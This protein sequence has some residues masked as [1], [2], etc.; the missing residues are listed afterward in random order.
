MTRFLTSLF[1]LAAIA[2]TVALSASCGKIRHRGDDGY[3]KVMIFYTAGYNSLSSYIREDLEDLKKGYLPAAKSR[4]A[5]ILISKL[6]V[7]YG[8]YN[9]KT[10][11]CIIRITGKKSGK[12]TVAVMDTLMTLEPGTVLANSRVTRECLEYVRDRFPSKSYGMVFSSHATGWL[13]GGYFDNPSAY[14]RAFSWRSGQNA[15]ASAGPLYVEREQDPSYPAVKS[16]TQE[17]ETIDKWKYSRE[18]EIEDLADAI[19]M[20]LD[21]LLFDACLMG[22]IEVAYAFRN[23][24]DVIGFS[25]TEVLADGYDYT[26]ITGHL[27]GRSEPDAKSV[28]SDFFNSYEIQTGMNRSATVSLVEC[29]KVGDIAQVC[30]RLFSKYRDSINSLSQFRV[31]GYFYNQ[32]RH[33]HFDLLDIIIQAGATDEEISE[34]RRVLDASLIYKAATPS[35]FELPLETTCGYSMYLPSAGSAYLDNFYRSLSWNQATHLVSE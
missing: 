31:Q 1:R 4:D 2:M 7:S 34:L 22:G 16:V 10:S 24:A 32:A 11:P 17:V 19:P 12:T 3:D 21:Y 20:H 29:S 15:R 5:L 33:W 6:P 9:T 28:C 23:V 25:Q 30:S 27:L 13:P 18:M 14:D 8:D 26:K 35:F